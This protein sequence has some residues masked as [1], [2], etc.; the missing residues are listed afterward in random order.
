MVINDKNLQPLQRFAGMEVL[1]GLQNLLFFQGKRKPECGPLPGLTLDTHRAAHH[2][3]EL[4]CDGQA[5]TCSAE[6][7]RDRSVPLGKGL[8]D[9][10]LHIF[11]K[12]DSRVRHFELEPQPT[13]VPGEHGHTN[14]H[15]ALFGELDAVADKI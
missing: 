13:P 15:V 8:E 14:D 1:F 4:F 7:P 10:L 3:G 6:T 12:S 2:L 9:V 11:R 5:E